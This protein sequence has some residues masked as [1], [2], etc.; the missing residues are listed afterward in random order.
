MTGKKSNT[1]LALPVKE[2][3]YGN[4]IQAV[5]GKAVF[6]FSEISKNA[7]VTLVCSICNKL[8]NSCN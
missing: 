1:F 7:L 5:A 4:K 3:L 6:I 8:L 2:K